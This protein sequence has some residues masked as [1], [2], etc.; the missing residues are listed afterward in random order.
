MRRDCVV[1]AVYITETAAIAEFR[2]YLR[3]STFG[4]YGAI[5]D[6]SGVPE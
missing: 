6:V 1:L 3:R 4:A 5:I 2:I